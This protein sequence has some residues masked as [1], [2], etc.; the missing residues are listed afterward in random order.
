MGDLFQDGSSERR[1][2]EWNSSLLAAHQRHLLSSLREPKGSC[3][4]AIVINPNKVR[5][6]WFAVHSETKQTSE[7]QHCCGTGPQRESLHKIPQLGPSGLLLLLL[8]RRTGP[9]PPGL[10]ILCAGRLS[11]HP[12]RL[13]SGGTLFALPLREGNEIPAHAVLCKSRVQMDCHW[14]GRGMFSSW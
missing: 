4:K 7:G 5:A 2:W 14:P 6:S 8:P 3:H 13:D 9:C 11:W 10:A 12:Q 1:R